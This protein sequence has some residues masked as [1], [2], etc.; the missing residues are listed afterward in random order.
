LDGGRVLRSIVWRATGDYRRATRVA[1]NGGRIVAGL[2]IAIGVLSV[3]F[4][5]EFG[6]LWWIVLGWFLFQAAGA[7]LGQL[8]VT[9]GLSGVTAAQVMTGTP[10]AVD[11]NLTL[12]QVF[13]DY[14]M[15]RNESSFP[16]VLEGRVR[17]LI[18]LKQLGEVPRDRWAVVLVSEIMQVLKPEDAVGGG[19]P[20]EELLA[21]LSMSG[22]QVVVV[23]EGRLVGMVSA[24]DI[25]RWLRQQSLS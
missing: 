12:Q 17:G 8:T 21:K 11:G 20:A 1:G 16:A 24:T 19:A 13:D 25:T 7:A 3:F 22:Q 6:G 5:G 4:R 10:V 23:E 18:S 2:M 14:F 9:A 15:A